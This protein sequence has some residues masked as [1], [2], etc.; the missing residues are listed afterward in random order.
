MSAADILV[1]GGRLSVIRALGCLGWLAFAAGLACRPEHAEQRARTASA[2]DTTPP[3]AEPSGDPLDTLRDI[4]TILPQSVRA[5]LDSQYGTWALALS[6]RMHWL[7]RRPPMTPVAIWG[8]FD[9]DGQV[10]C[11]VQIVYTDSLNARAQSLVA[12]L[13]RAGRGFEA[14]ILEHQAPTPSL[15]LK[16]VQRGEGAHD[17]CGKYNNGDPFTY[18]HDAIFVAM[19]D[20]AGYT[21]LYDKGKFILIYTSD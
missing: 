3:H 10:D 20:K 4:V 12:L 1:R 9:G 21:S 7:E 13:A 16:L 6:L 17:Y 19:G 15:G 2:V 8:D 14:Y 5:V 11:A 18:P